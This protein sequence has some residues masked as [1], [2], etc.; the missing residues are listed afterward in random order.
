MENLPRH[1]SKEQAFDHATKEII[2]AWEN[3]VSAW[4]L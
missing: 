3:E 4:I 1:I 2:L